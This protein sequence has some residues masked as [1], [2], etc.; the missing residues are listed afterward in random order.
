[1][2]MFRN[3]KSVRVVIY[4]I[5]VAAQV[6]SFFVTITSPELA[7]AFSQTSDVLGTLALGTALTNMN[8]FGGGESVGDH[9]A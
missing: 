5:G 8:D 7:Q 9:A 6:A 3:M 1:M 4:L 2:N